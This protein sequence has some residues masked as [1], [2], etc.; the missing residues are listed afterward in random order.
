MLFGN[1]PR[2]FRDGRPSPGPGHYDAAEA[3]LPLAPNGQLFPVGSGRASYLTGLL[4]GEFFIFKTREVRVRRQGFLG[5]CDLLNK[6]SF[7]VVAA[8]ETRKRMATLKTVDAF[9]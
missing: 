2:F 9:Y 4:K 1:S 8:S 7:N 6:P 3:Q 5:Q